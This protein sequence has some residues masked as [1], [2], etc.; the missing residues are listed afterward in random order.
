LPDECLNALNGVRRDGPL[1][2]EDAQQPD[3][4]EA[5]IRV[6]VG[7]FANE[8]LESARLSNPL[9]SLPLPKDW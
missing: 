1:P 5:R 4:G 8:I 9:P 2:V 3:I 7:Y 6:I